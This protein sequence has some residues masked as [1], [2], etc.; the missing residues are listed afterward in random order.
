MSTQDRKGIEG[1]WLEYSGILQECIEALPIGL[2]SLQTHSQLT[3][4]EIESGSP[5]IKRQLG[6]INGI[7]MVDHCRR[8]ESLL[9]NH[10]GQ[11]FLGISAKIIRDDSIHSSMIHFFDNVLNAKP[12]YLATICRTADLDLETLTL[13]AVYAVRPIRQA[14]MMA[15]RSDDNGQEWPYG[16][17][18]VCGLWPRMAIVDETTSELHLWCIGCGGAWRFPRLVCPFCFERSP[19]RFGYLYLNDDSSYRIYTCDRCRRY[20]KTKLTHLKDK[21][22]PV[23]LDVEYMSSSSLDEMARIERYIQDFV[24][25]AAFDLQDNA[26]ARAYRKQACLMAHMNPGE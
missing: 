23:S 9:V 14:V 13:F 24:G 17:C 16:Y 12:T 7:V 26:A 2:E 18:P 6:A 5:F 3:L 4:Q 22:T 15:G 8:L 21:T 1:F 10:L 20:L 19:E 11:A 25:F